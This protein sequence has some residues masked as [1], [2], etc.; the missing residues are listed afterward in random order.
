M[1]LLSN[2]K[3]GYYRCRRAYTEVHIPRGSSALRNPFFTLAELH[4]AKNTDIR[5]GCYFP[6]LADLEK[7]VKLALHY[8]NTILPVVTLST[9]YDPL[10][11]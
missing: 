8:I 6:H 4:A 3:I 5:E 7:I 9:A 2:L 1:L 10:V 11:P